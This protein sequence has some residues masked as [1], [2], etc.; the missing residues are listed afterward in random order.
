MADRAPDRYSG[1]LD[2]TRLIAYAAEQ[3]GARRIWSASQF[4]E[5]GICGYR[6]FAKR[7]LK[8]ETLKEP[9]DGMDAMQ[10]GT[11]IHAILEETYRHLAEN[12]ISIAPENLAEFRRI[13]TE[14]R[15][16]RLRDGA[17]RWRL[18]QDAQ[19]SQ[20]LVE[21]F[22]VES[23]AEHLRQHARTTVQ[24]RDI[25]ATAQALHLGPEKPKIH[26]YFG[27]EE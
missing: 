15:E 4:N 9:E 13:M 24:D 10:R 18:Y 17:R 14:V 3:L 11:L 16:R 22:R 23:W 6:F 26:H 7:L 19:D 8:L 20:R 2:D 25:E 12:G 1:R 5:Y 21:L 27:V